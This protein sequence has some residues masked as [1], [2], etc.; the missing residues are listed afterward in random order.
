MHTLLVLINLC[1]HFKRIVNESKTECKFQHNF[2]LS[3][4]VSALAYNNSLF[5]SHSCS[6]LLNDTRENNEQLTGFKISTYTEN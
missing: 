6:A 4:I 2:C 1:T 3:K 5:S